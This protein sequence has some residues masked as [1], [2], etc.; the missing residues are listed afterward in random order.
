[1]RRDF[2]ITVL[3]VNE[4]PVVSIFT[5]TAGQQTFLDNHA[6]ITENSKLG[7]VVGTIEATDPVSHNAGPHSMNLIQHIEWHSSTSI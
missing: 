6:S 2:Q 7:T 4:A 3:N 1:M 5:D